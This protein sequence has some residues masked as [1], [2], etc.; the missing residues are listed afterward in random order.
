MGLNIIKE[1]SASKIKD[2]FKSFDYFTYLY[3]LSTIQ[4]TKQITKSFNFYN[5]FIFLN[6]KHNRNNDY[7]S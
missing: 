4:I 5:Y 2:I 7:F 1:K 6:N 3:L